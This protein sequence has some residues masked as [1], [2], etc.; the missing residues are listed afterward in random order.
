MP[1][2]E[3]FHFGH[4]KSIEK[5]HWFT[6]FIWPHL[7]VD[8]LFIKHENVPVHTVSEVAELSCGCQE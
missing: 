5:Y 1:V 7:D 3:D 4:G 8:R 6:L 2:S